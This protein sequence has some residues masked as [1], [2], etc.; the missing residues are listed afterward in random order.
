MSMVLLFFFFRTYPFFVLLLFFSA[1][2]ACDSKIIILEGFRP[3]QQFY[4]FEHTL[5]KMLF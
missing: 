1:T 4:F 5:K 3:A 2:V